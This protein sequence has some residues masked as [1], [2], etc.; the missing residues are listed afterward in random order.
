MTF[1]FPADSYS[2]SNTC[3]GLGALLGMRSQNLGKAPRDQVFHELSLFRSERL[4]RADG[5][6][7]WP[8]AVRGLRPRAGRP[9]HG[10]SASGKVLPD[11]ARQSGPADAVAPRRPSRTA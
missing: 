10:R 3:T 7:R 2:F 1:V 4:P 11:R 6:E 8:V 9:G 5:P